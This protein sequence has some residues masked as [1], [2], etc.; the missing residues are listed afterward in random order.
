MSIKI[1]SQCWPIR[2]VSAVAKAVLMSMADQADDAGSCWPA[3]K[4]TAERTCLSTRSVIRGIKELEAANLLRADRSNGRHSTYI[5]QPNGCLQPVPSGHECQSGTCDAQTQCHAP[6]SSAYCPTVT[7]ALTPRH[8][9]HKQRSGTIK[10]TSAVDGALKGLPPQLLHDFQQLRIKQRL[11]ITTTVLE[12]FR[13]SADQ[14]GI[15]LE[16][17]IRLITENSW[18]TFSANWLNRPAAPPGSERTHWSD[19]QSGV[20]RR[21]QELGFDLWDPVQEDWPKYKARVV[22]ADRDQRTSSSAT[23]PQLTVVPQPRKA[24]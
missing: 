18:R 9:N 10:E 19:R 22:N 14:A 13:R 1:S 8:T 20:E 24:A 7:G 5:V 23:V 12:G 17:V 4:K 3:I 2:T 21:A 15:Q 6:E 16:D 11:P